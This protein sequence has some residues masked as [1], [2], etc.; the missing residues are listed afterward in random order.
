LLKMLLFIQWVVLASLSKIKWP[1]GWRF[2]S[3]TSILFQL[4]SC[5][6]LSQYHAV[7][8]LYCSVIQF[9]VRYSNFPQKLFYCWE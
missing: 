6:S 7:F 4:S 8:N 2:I 9:E 1:Y 5:L 3:G